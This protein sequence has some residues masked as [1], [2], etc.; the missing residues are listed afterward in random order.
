MHKYT[1]DQVREAIEL[2][3][4]D[5]AAMVQP[6]LPPS[7]YRKADV[8]HSFGDLTIDIEQSF[9]VSCTLYLT[10]KFNL[11]TQELTLDQALDNVD[12]KVKI[13]WSST[14]RDLTNSQ[15]A[16]SL[17]SRMCEIGCLFEI[18]FHERLKYILSTKD[19]SKNE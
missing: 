12:A 8:R 10:P 18:S 17:Y 3:I 2:T 14:G 11:T 19:W 5:L 7:P 6:M 16:I 9:G 15:A 13:S 4:T 1:R